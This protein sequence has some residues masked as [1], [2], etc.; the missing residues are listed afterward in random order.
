MK[1]DF[2]SE[3]IQEHSKEKAQEIAEYI[4]EHPERF[5]ELFSLLFHDNIRVVQRAAWP[6][7]M[8]GKKNPGLFSPYFD[9][10]VA[11]IENPPHDAVNRNLY[12]I[13]QD[14][15]I[16]EEYHAPIFNLCIR[17]LADAKMPVAMKAFGM[18]VAFNISK[19]Y[20]ELQ[21]EL[22]LTIEENSKHQTPGY[23]SRARKILPK[24][25]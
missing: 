4:L 11:F 2:E 24:L 1:M 18:T 19:L 16:P 21:P 12:R 22:K 5:S 17:D 15:P 23:Y 25:S 20:P 10:I 8:L 14:L 6:I 9:K 3:I 7:G 13:L